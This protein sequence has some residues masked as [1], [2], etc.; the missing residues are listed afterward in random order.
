MAFTEPSLNVAIAEVLHPMS[1]KWEVTAELTD[2]IP[3]NKQLVLDI[4][5]HNYRRLPVV[6]ENEIEP[7][8][9]VHSDAMWR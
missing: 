5:I 9:N 1:S 7:A 6:I 3:E 4:F 8:H 2:E